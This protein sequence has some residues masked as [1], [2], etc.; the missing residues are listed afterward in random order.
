M[1]ILEKAN[2][3]V[4]GDRN[5]AYGHPHEDFSRTARLW[6]VILDTDVTAE[7]AALCMAALKISRQCNKPKED[8]MVDLAGYAQVVQMIVEYEDDILPF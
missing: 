2:E 1:N 6:S 8:N 5:D 7:Q 3:L 4:N